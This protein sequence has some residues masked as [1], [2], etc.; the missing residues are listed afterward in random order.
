M[1][2]QMDYESLY[3]LYQSC[4]DSNAHLQHELERLT[5]ELAKYK[6]QPIDTVPKD[7]TRVILHRSGFVEGM[8][9]GFYSKIVKGLIVVGNSIVFSGADSWMPLPNTPKAP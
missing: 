5:D 1:T 7:G 8:T 4:L 6:W 3:A 9:I 2:E